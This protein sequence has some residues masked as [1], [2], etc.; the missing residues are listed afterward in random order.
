MRSRNP[1]LFSLCV[2]VAPLGLGMVW[3]GLDEICNAIG[4]AIGLAFTG[5]ALM[6]LYLFVMPI[7]AIGSFLYMSS[8]KKE[9]NRK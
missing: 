2:T 9:W 4:L 7:V 3:L 8:R 1:I 5:M 6:Y